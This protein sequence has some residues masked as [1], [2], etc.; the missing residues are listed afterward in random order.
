MICLNFLQLSKNWLAINFARQ[1]VEVNLS[2]KE[3]YVRLISL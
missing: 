3:D 2:Q 1:V